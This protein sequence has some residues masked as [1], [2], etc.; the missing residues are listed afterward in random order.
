MA[1]MVKYRCL[2]VKNC[3]PYTHAADR[4]SGIDRLWSTAAARFKVVLDSVDVRQVR[5][6]DGADFRNIFCKARH[7]R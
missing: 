1:E 6:Q 7:A 2:T 4:N 3:H 5:L